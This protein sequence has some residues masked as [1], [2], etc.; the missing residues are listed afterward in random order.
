MS[1]HVSERVR[2]ILECYEIDGAF[3]TGSEYPTIDVRAHWNRNSFVVLVVD[4]KTYTVSR[5][6]LENA[7]ENCTNWSRP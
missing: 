5:V 3:S 6:E 7:L 1:R 2:H 4:G